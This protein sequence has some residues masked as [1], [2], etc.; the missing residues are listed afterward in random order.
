MIEALADGGVMMGLPRD[1]AMEHAAA[2][3]EGSA[4]M[5]LQG[6]KHPAA[7]KDEVCS[8]GGSTIRFVHVW[9]FLQGVPPKNITYCICIGY[10]STYK[11]WIDAQKLRYSLCKNIN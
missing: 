9:R 10:I 3:V 5:V 11:P 1:L 4:G 2:M 6:G 8:P 7:L